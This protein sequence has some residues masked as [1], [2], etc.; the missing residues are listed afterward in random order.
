MQFSQ[1]ENPDS[2]AE[3]ISH[4]GTRQLE[5]MI[6]GAYTIGETLGKGHWAGR[7]SLDVLFRVFALV[8]DIRLTLDRTEHFA[9]AYLG[10]PVWAITTAPRAII[11]PF[12]DDATLRALGGYPDDANGD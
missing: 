6:S 7:A 3:E 2:A 1:S 11:L 10:T 5:A 12:L 4:A 8:K 9:T